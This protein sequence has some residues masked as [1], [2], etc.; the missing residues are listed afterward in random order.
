MY[1]SSSNSMVTS[2]PRQKPLPS[3]V[4]ILPVT[5]RLPTALIPSIKCWVTSDVCLSVSGSEK[6]YSL[7]ISWSDSRPST[8]FARERWLRQR[9]E[10]S[11]Q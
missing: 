9:W 2:M 8:E 6:S 3:G 10:T 11:L 5:L 4:G 1:F 7:R